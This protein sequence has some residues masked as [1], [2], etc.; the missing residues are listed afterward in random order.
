MYRID[1]MYDPMVEALL[2]A[3]SENKADRWMAGVA[4]WLGRQQ[5]Y[6]VPDYWLELAAKI[7][8][9]LD[10]ADKDAI[11]DQL[12]KSETALIGAAGD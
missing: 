8:S 7:T 9:G 2:A 4:F 12:S 3:R 11:L 1:S 10:V 5:I 6:N